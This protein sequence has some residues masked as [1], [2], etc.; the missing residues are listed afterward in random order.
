MD[1]INADLDVV[2]LGT[3]RVKTGQSTHGR[4]LWETGE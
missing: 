2:K 3:E 1:A 4:G